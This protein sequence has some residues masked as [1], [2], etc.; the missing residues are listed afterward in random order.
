MKLLSAV[1]T[2]N[3]DF[4]RELS[5]GQGWIE[6]EKTH[7]LDLAG[8][9]GMAP[10]HLAAMGGFVK[11]IEA[12]ADVKADVNVVTD[13]GG[14]SPL[15]LAAQ[16]QHYPTMLALVRHGANIEA[17]DNHGQTPIHWAARQGKSEAV[18]SLVS[19]NAS[20]ECVDSMGFTPLHAA[21]RL[22][23]TETI[24]ALLDSGANA[25]AKDECG[26][27]PAEWAQKAEVKILLQQHANSMRTQKN[28]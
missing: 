14:M 16:L 2:G 13:L 23:Q 11:C 22:G 25:S 26:R 21:T 18:L 28:T 17:N 20:L 27:A 5:R 10:M 8:Q 15:H 3:H 1:R 9:D 6:G 12:L 7:E 19:L 4:I 24:K